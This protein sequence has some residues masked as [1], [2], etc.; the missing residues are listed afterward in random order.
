MKK[1]SYILN[2]L[3]ILGLTAF[4]LWFALKDNFKEVIGLLKGIP[5][6]FFAII[7]IYGLAYNLIIGWIYKLIGRK[8]KPNY[9]YKE[10]LAVAFVGA[11]FAG[12]TPSATGGQFGQAYLLKN[13][14]IK[15]SSAASILWIDFIIYQSVMVIYTTF[16]MIFKYAYYQTHYSSFFVL[17]LIGWVVNSSVIVLL[18]TMAKFPKAYQRLSQGI[19]K[20]LHKVHIVKNPE[21]TILSWNNSLESFNSEIHI[22]R[23]EKKM[24]LQVGL[25]NVVRLTVL[26][27]LPLFIAYTMGITHVAGGARLSIDLLPDV[28]T[29]SAFVM[30]ANAFFPVPGASGGTEAAFILIF[31]FLFTSAQARG[32]MILWRFATYHAV[33]LIGGLTFMYCKSKYDRAK[34]AHQIK[35][36][37]YYEDRYIH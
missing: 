20:L 4:A 17:V 29:M 26:Y 15:L 37:D 12:I 7:L 10:S 22:L 3:M 27:S 1:K 5:W 19:I 23:D 24:V 31:S 13:Q 25:L 14:G 33:I 9:T 6:Y 34:S 2:F 8:N 18:A 35:E 11:F 32:I 28:I 16:I 30:I 21:A 36:E